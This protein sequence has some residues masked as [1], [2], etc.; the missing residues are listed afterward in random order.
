MEV[1]VNSFQ[2]LINLLVLMS[3]LSVAAE[4]LTNVLKLRDEKLREERS[5]PGE[6]RERE[7][8]IGHRALVVSVLLA[9]AIKADFFE[10]LA[11]LD[12]PWDTLGWIRLAGPAPL[13]HWADESPAQFLYTVAGTVLTGISMGFGSKFWHDV[14]DIVY[15]T[16]TRIR[17]ANRRTIR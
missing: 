11:H 5:S 4:R 15:S 3:A 6:E 17:N 16:R 7:R 14:L 13:K 2:P 12:A 10:I 9:L 1:G 8:L